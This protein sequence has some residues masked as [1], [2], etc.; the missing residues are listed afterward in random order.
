MAHH[1]RR[2]PKKARA[3]CMLCKPRKANGA[4]CRHTPQ[5]LRARVGEREQI[6]DRS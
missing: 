1:K 2:R 3:G 6:G 5:E 4:K